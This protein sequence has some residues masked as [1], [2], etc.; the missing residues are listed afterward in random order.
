MVKL[1]GSIFASWWR[2]D[3]L[4]APNSGFKV[5]AMLIE[6]FSIEWSS[7]PTPT[8]NTKKQWA[9]CMWYL[10]HL[11]PANPERPDQNWEHT[12]SSKGEGFD[13]KVYSDK[14]R[15]KNRSAHRD[16]SFRSA[17]NL[18]W[19]GTTL[20][21]GRMPDTENFFSFRWWH[22]IKIEP[23]VKKRV[24]PFYQKNITD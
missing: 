19:L 23:N 11:K 20:L 1:V 16:K 3:N 4:W 14:K 2:C 22:Q 7:P 17:G 18:I 15:R 6:R 12:R 8:L 24:K 9:V 5:I 10:H 21:R 13:Q